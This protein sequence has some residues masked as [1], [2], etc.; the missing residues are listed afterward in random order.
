LKLLVAKKLHEA[1]RLALFHASMIYLLAAKA[2]GKISLSLI[3]S[4][5][6]RKGR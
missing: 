5:S 2:G 6:Y 3:G 4:L 1:R